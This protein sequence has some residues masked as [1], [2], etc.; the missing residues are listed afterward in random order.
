MAL[1]ELG[2]GS[3]LRQ[4]KLVRVVNTV[5]VDTSTGQEDHQR[6]NA[7]VDVFVFSRA[8]GKAGGTAGTQ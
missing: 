3:G 5:L 4:G 1:V 6:T 2:G 8:P 7:S